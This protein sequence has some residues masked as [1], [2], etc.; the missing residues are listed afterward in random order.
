MVSRRAT[1]D[2]LVPSWSR[3]V[4]VSAPGQRLGDAGRFDHQVIE[5]AFFR[6]P[7]DLDQKVLAQ[8]AADAAVAHLDQFLLGAVELDLLVH[9]LG[10][11]VDLGHVVDDDRDAPP[12]AIVE[13]VVE[14]RGLAGA[15]ETGQHRHR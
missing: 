6:Q 14:Q 7:A 4:K 1:S 13:D 15:E 12:L 11:D 8:R 3:K 5:P 2:R 10:V 9:Q